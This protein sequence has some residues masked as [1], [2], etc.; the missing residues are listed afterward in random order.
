MTHTIYTLIIYNSEGLHS[1]TNVW[2]IATF[3]SLKDAREAALECNRHWQLSRTITEFVHDL[4]SSDVDDL[5]DS[6]T[7]Y[8]V[9]ADCDNWSIYDEVYS[10]LR[11]AKAA[12]KQCSDVEH[13]NVRIEKINEV[14]IEEG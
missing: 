8:R 7:F 4:D 2:D 1:C 3:T 10:S 9:C 6:D 5:L 14:L 11:E 13:C 12:A